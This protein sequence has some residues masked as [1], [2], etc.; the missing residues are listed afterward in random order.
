M[1]KYP[2]LAVAVLVASNMTAWGYAS[3]E[4]G[5]LGVNEGAGVQIS[6][7]DAQSADYSRYADRSGNINLTFS[8][9][10]TCSYIGAKLESGKEFT[11]GSFSYTTGHDTHVDGNGSMSRIVDNKSYGISGGTCWQFENR[12]F[13]AVSVDFSSDWRHKADDRSQ[14]TIRRVSTNSDALIGSVSNSALHE[15]DETPVNFNT[16]LAYS[17]SFGKWDILFKTTFFTNQDGR[18]STI[19]ET[20]LDN[21]SYKVMSRSMYKNRM[22]ASRLGLAFNDMLDF[23]SE[24]SYSY[25]YSDYFLG[26]KVPATQASQNDVVEN[27]VSAYAKLHYSIDKTSL[28]AELNCEHVS[29]SYANVLDRSAGIDHTEN[30]LYP[31]VSVN[32]RIMS[33]LNCGLDYSCRA[34]RPDFNLF[35]NSMRY[36]SRFLFMSGN[37]ELTRQ[38]EQR[39]AFSLDFTHIGLFRIAGNYIRLDNPIIQT[40]SRIEKPSPY[41]TEGAIVE[42][43]VNA[44]SPMRSLDVD[45]EC[46]IPFGGM[47]L[48]LD[49]GIYDQWFELSADND[50]TLSFSGQPV[51]SAKAAASLPLWKGGSLNPE[52]EFRSSGNRRNLYIENST[53]GLNASFLQEFKRLTLKIEGRDLLKHT[54][55]NTRIDCGDVTVRKCYMADTRRIQA[56]LS[57]S[58]GGAVMHCHTGRAAGHEVLNRM[59]YKPNK[60]IAYERE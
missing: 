50:V 19:S 43:P 55:C 41:Y 18:N 30:S 60:S 58:I 33:G 23:G 14:N 22:V 51:W 42:K 39:L 57:Y 2:V 25:H 17:G 36:G 28:A 3:D 38:L 37:T 4:D 35:D 52:F 48:E 56:T 31:L 34:L 32:S 46:L 9:E 1:K 53:Y 27:T 11:E 21:S 20:G 15:N 26:G 49:G 59:K 54:Y 5:W 44:G 29:F 47:L 40:F 16:E 13:L 10:N 7:S 45:L 12:S 6:I 8:G 24:V